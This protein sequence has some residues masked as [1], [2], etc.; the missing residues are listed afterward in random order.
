MALCLRLGIPIFSS[1]EAGSVVFAINLKQ[2]HPLSHNSKQP[3]YLTDINEQYQEIHCFKD[4]ISNGY[5]PEHN[6]EK[7]YKKLPVPPIDPDNPIVKASTKPKICQNYT[8]VPHPK[9]SEM[10]PQ[11]S[12]L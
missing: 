8:Y 6:E 11:N 7:A 2:N 3:D 5:N 12:I 1:L 4:I 10:F 9:Q